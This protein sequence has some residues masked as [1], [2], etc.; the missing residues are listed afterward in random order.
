MNR[1][2]FNNLLIKLNMD[3]KTFKETPEQQWK[4]L[5]TAFM[6]KIAG[7]KE[8]QSWQSFFNSCATLVAR[9][10]LVNSLN[11]AETGYQHLS[12]TPP[13]KEPEQTAFLLVRSKE[14]NAKSYAIKGP[15]EQIGRVYEETKGIFRFFNKP[16]VFEFK[17]EKEF[18]GSSFYKS[19]SEK[20]REA[21][22]GD[23]FPMKV[24][25]YTFSNQEEANKFIKALQEKK[26]ITEKPVT[27]NTAAQSTQSSTA[28]TPLNM[29]LTPS[30]LKG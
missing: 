8:K 11:H 4:L 12:S 19:L 29:I 13:S 7:E 14:E 20:D 27:A 23:N 28:P 16:D 15:S 25:Q 10:N 9:V 22:K 1:Q 2:D 6:Q 21:Y 17:S 3:E 30:M 26:M 5:A 18:Q 24:T